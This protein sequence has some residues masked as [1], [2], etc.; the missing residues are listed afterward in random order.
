M[1]KDDSKVTTKKGDTKGDS[2]ENTR[3]SAKGGDTITTSLDK[4]V[5]DD[6]KGE[7]D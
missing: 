2:K 7:K 3:N 5:T 4:T 6:G 1:V